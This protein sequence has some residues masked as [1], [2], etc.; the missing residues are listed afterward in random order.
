MA[1]F[2]EPVNVTNIFAEKIGRVFVVEGGFM[3]FVLCV[4]RLADDGITELHGTVVVT[5]PT[6]AVHDGRALTDAALACS[7]N[8]LIDGRPG[9]RH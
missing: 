2:T 6:S 8:R 9:W 1:Q 4:T 7:E 3:R 5:M